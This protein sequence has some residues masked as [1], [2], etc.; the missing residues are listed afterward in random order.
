MSFTES[1]SH[2]FANCTTFKGRAGRSEYWWFNLFVI[3]VLLPA[4][5]FFRFGFTEHTADLI[6]VFINIPILF[7]CATVTVRRLHDTNRTGWWCL[8]GLI[9]IIGPVIML[10]F[11][12]LPG[13]EGHNSF[14]EPYKN[15]LLDLPARKT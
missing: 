4:E 7:L 8:T 3:I 10:F 11:L 5:M 15:R 2:V 13:T 14:G 1:I 9:P 6:S 12:V